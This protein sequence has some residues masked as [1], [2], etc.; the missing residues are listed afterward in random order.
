MNTKRVV[1]IVLALLASLVTLWVLGMWLMRSMT[2]GSGMMG[3]MACPAFCFLP[4]LLVGVAVLVLA[5]VLLRR[6]RMR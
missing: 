1:L 3:S 6:K 2:M 5:I 4:L